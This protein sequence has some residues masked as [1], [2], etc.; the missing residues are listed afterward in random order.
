V[1]AL[2]Y[3]GEE[4]LV[5]RTPE[6]AACVRVDLEVHDLGVASASTVYEGI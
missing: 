1:Q 4:E 5:I 6:V 3:R 2:V